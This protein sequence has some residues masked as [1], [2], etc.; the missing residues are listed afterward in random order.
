MQRM[1]GETYCEL[2]NKTN[3]PAIVQSR[4]SY[5]LMTI[6]FKKSRIGICG[7]LVKSMLSHCSEISA[8]GT[9]W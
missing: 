9:H 5:D 8:F 7:R 1:C 4:N 3:N 2:A 6:N